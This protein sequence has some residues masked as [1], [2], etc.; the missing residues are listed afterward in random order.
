MQAPA[1]RAWAAL[2]LGVTRAL[3]ALATLVGVVVVVL[4]FS[5]VVLRFAGAQVPPAFEELG[6]FLFVWWVFLGAAMTLR[7]VGHPRITV[8]VQLLPEGLRG[9]VEL[10]SELVSL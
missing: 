6:S 5:Q 2:L 4:I 1:A 3:R 10:A 9:E 8:F 7:E